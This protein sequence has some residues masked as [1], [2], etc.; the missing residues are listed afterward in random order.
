MLPFWLLLAQAKSN[1]L[2]KRWLKFG[3]PLVTLVSGTTGFQ[4]ELLR[5]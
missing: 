4:V 5:V 2:Q 1:K 3:R